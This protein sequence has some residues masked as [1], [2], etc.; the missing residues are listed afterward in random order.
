MFERRTAFSC[1]HDFS[2]I[3]EMLMHDNECQ[4][5]E[6]QRQQGREFSI[7]PLLSSFSGMRFG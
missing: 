6:R 2:V 4:S 7:V 3:L 1:A 5:S